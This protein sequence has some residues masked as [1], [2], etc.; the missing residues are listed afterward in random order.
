M[1]KVREFRGKYF[2][3]SNFSEYP[4]KISGILFPTVEHAY[5]ACK[6]DNF[7]MKRIIGSAISPSKAKYYGRWVECRKDWDQIKIK[8]M[9]LCLRRKF[10][11]SA[12]ARKLLLETGDT[13]LEE[14]NYWN[15]TFWGVCNGIGENH[16]GK[17]LM[18]IR[19]DLR[20]AAEGIS[21]DIIQKTEC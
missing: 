2:F 21:G 18:K 12:K 10:E 3:L 11:K 13:Y 7:N 1:E 20:S 8:V 9:E 14:G 5:Q 16:L 6:T 4:C 15:D 19:E 17:L